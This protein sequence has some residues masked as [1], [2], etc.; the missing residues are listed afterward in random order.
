MYRASSGALVFGTGTVQWS[1]GLDDYHLADPGTPTDPVMQ[2]ATLNVL[3][4]MG[5]Q[6]QTRQA[7]LV[8]A[9]ASS[10]TLAPTTTITSPA[11]G[12]QAPIGSPVTVAGSA[13]D[14]GGGIVAAVEVSIGG[15]AWHPA[16]G[17]ESWSYVFTPTSTGEMQ[18]RVRAVDDS[19][20]IGS[21]AVITVVGAARSYPCPIWAEGTT[22]QTEATDETTP[23]EVG[24]RFQ[25]DIDGFITG[26]RFYKGAGN[27]GTHVGTLWTA[28][29]AERA[30]ATF[31]DETPTGWQ[32]VPISPTPVAAGTTY[33]A[34]VFM[35]AGRY[36]ADAG[37]FSSAYELAPLRALANGEGGA[38]NGV[39]RYGSAGFPTNSFGSTNY[40]VD[41]M[42]DTDNREGPTVIS[43]APGAGLQSVALS[44]SV[45]ASFSEAVSGVTMA[46]TD[47][48]GG[49]VSGT[50]TYEGANRSA[51]FVPDGDLQP[52]TQ[53]T[54]QVA[55]AVDVSGNDIT[56]FTWAFT[57]T[58]EP[59]TSPTS[60]WD[61]SAA[62]TSFDDSQS[63]LELGLKFSTVKAGSIT[64]LRFFKAPG[65]SGLHV[66]HLW[67]GAGTLL[68]TGTYTNETASGW[69]QVNL[70]TPVELAPNTTYVTSY[71]APKGGY[72]ATGGYFSSS[73]TE[74]GPLRAPKGQTVGGNG[75]YAYGSGGFPT[76]SY[77][78][79]NYW[80]DV[81][82]EV[83]GDTGPPDVIN[84]VPAPGLIEVPRDTVVTAEF[85]EP[86][87]PALIAF[88]VA[89]AAG[90]DVPGSTT[91]DAA[92]ATATFTP[93][94]ELASNAVFTAS[95]I[96]TDT[97][98]NSAP[99][100]ATW[101]F[102][103]VNGGSSPVTLWDSGALP[104]TE[105]V[106]ETS[107]VELGVRVRSSLAGRV[108]GLRFFKGDGN[109]GPHLGRLWTATG[110]LLGSLS[111]ANE[112]R[113]G[114]QQAYFSEAISISAN[115][116]YVASYHTPS[117]RYAVTA[118]G[119]S[120]AR[121]RGSLT[122][123]ASTSQAGNGLF[124]Y[125]SGGFPNNSWNGGNYWV[126][127]IFADSSGPSIED[128]SP[129]PGSTA[130]PNTQVRVTFDEEV[131]ESTIALSL[132]DGGG[133]AVAGSVSYDAESRTATF[134]PTAPL[135]AGATFTATV[136]GAEDLQG[137]AMAESVSW[138]FST[139]G[140]GYA[141]IWPANTTPATVL[142]N[143]SG[144]LEVG[145]KFRTSVAGAIHGV[146][147]Y[148]GGPDNSGPHVG[149]L[150][151]ADGTSLATAQFGGE[152]ARGWQTVVF[153]APVPVTADQTYVA[154]YHAPNGNYSVD[155]R[156]FNGSST[157]R[158]DLEA[159]QNGQDGGNGV[160]VYSSA[161]AFPSRSY[162]ASN[163]WVDVLF[164]TD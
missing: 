113:R 71:Y 121:T 54:A 103:T 42:F 19:C 84:R 86:V 67:D 140:A 7:G 15:G 14:S 155:G 154:S 12:A 150:W 30:Q 123:P 98:G 5:A 8:A 64:G 108:T 76:S 104:A 55:T 25:A 96:A 118:G 28:N 41:V 110:T 39:Y 89:D 70:D 44:T 102:T 160:Y 63:A 3:A 133:A 18:V 161:T 146:R 99:E 132:R 26:L 158:G 61:T 148:K 94:S 159:L 72:G 34:S 139:L 157:V 162:N 151:A 125:G 48:N 137:N 112:T 135:A 46:L 40:W 49:E 16:T 81:V 4:D 37:Y 164:V 33:V 6:P 129:Q 69:Q 109:E 73:G 124:A 92:T 82:F 138:G 35:P 107:A 50:M 68:A 101:S 57:T 24:V 20:N 152:T 131:M 163:Y 2:Q 75:V 122:A 130:D 111:F 60:I 59:G 21:A 13:V 80:V 134:A 66:G 11:D 147:F 128:R 23:I 27:T 100:A 119:L 38:G 36:P 43:Q 58:G 95:V 149:N 136:D 105:A 141:T 10:D 65:S 32:T 78:S 52:L 87:A 117:G 91:Y 153:S 88:S 127:V 106:N 56:P 143:D 29:G 120:D 145:V 77:N 115:T 17:K 9:S 85:S 53:Y 45:V 1:Y 62:P 97:A 22:P 142:S 47:A 114:W 79:G 126:D 116:A 93:Q 31:A 74:R 83:A 51:T 90:A 144:S 156:Y